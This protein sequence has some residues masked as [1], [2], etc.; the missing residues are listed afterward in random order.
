MKKVI[1]SLL[2]VLFSLSNLYAENVLNLYWKDLNIV[3]EFPEIVCFIQEA[4]DKIIKHTYKK[5]KTIR[6]GA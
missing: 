3:D 2:F 1:F 5:A 6:L 4:D